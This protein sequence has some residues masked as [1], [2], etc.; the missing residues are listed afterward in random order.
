MVHD[1]HQE[2]RLNIMS[3]VPLHSLDCVRRRPGMYIGD[4]DETGLI[5]CVFELLANSIEQHLAGLCSTVLVTVHSDG[6]L[7]VEDD[8][9]GIPTTLDPEYDAPFIEL[10]FTALDYAAKQDERVKPFVIGLAGVGAKCV[11]ALSEWM[12][13]D[14]GNTTGWF[15][16]EFSKGRVIERLRET[17][18]PGR[19]HGTTIRFK[20]DPEIFHQATFS[21][22]A[23][24][25]IL[26]SIAV[27]HPG[28]D[29]WLMDERP[30]RRNLPLT[31][32]FFYS[33]GIADFLNAA[34]SVYPRASLAPV[35]FTGEANGIRCALGFCFTESSDTLIQS[36]VND[37]RTRL[38]GTH[39]TGF[40]LGVADALNSIARLQRPLRPNEV[41][42]GLVAFIGVWL[43][44]PRYGGSTKD[45]LINAEVELFVRNLTRDNIERWI[46]G[47]HISDWVID[48]IEEQ[49][50]S[51]ERLDL[52]NE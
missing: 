26:H 11:N 40:L 50:Q 45:E 18:D 51:L 43:T 27:L 19:R 32:Q 35:A 8:G 31:R 29:V 1:S 34:T 30:N 52:Q 44:G 20:P 37:Q 25:D 5:R 47:S 4:P 39:L 9:S 7:S 46:A 17:R 33:N 36:F 23:L 24:E 28:F 10:A 38:G 3:F 14:T 48:F 16:I 12:R 49:R 22:G 41:R 15:H 2:Q 42:S 21:Q 13:I 6:S